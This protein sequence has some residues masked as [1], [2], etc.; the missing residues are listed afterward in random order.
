MSLQMALC[1]RHFPSASAESV[2]LTCPLRL[3]FTSRC[4]GALVGCL[5]PRPR[6][7][8]PD[9]AGGREARPSRFS[10]SGTESR[11]TARPEL[12]QS[13]EGANQGDSSRVLVATI[14]FASFT[15]S[16][17]RTQQ[18]RVRTGTRP[19]AAGTL[20]FT[21]CSLNRFAYQ[22]LQKCLGFAQCFF[23]SVLTSVIF[24]SSR[25]L[26]EGRT[27]AHISEHV[28]G[29]SPC[30]GLFHAHRWVWGGGTFLWSC[31]SGKLGKRSREIQS[32]TA[33]E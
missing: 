26:G 32:H 9:A 20:D 14:A 4:S 16:G 8:S 7:L 6:W 19:V 27:R 28:L 5:L 17:F 11:R 22:P 23:Q 1:N 31:F 25:Q 24:L 10:R 3:D 30:V 2:P 18:R 21:I 29:A 33:K 12:A 13:L 15:S